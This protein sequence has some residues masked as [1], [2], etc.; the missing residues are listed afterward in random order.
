MTNTTIY[1]GLLSG[2]VNLPISKSIAHR[3]IL[4]KALSGNPIKD[5]KDRNMPDDIW[6]TLQG[7][8]ALVDSLSLDSL[9]I[10]K[11][12]NLS[13]F[14][15]K[16][17]CKDSGTTLRMIMPIACAIH[18]KVQITVTKALAKRP[19]GELI[20][21]LSDHGCKIELI[22]NKDGTFTYHTQGKFQGGQCHIAGN[23]SS[24]YISGLLYALPLT[25]NGGEIQLTTELAS[26]P[27]LDMTLTILRDF[28]INIDVSQTNGLDKFTLSGMQKFK[29]T[30]VNI[31]Q[32]DWSAAAFFAVANALG[33][34]V[35]MNNLNP[36]SIQGDKEVYNFI[37]KIST[38]KCPIIDLE[39][40][41]D[42]FPVLA[43]L[44]CY[45]KKKTTFTG[46]SRLEL[47]ESNRIESTKAMIDALGG[48]MTIYANPAIKVEIQ[49]LGYL[50]GGTVNSYND[51][52]IAMAAAIAASRA[53]GPVT[54]INSSCCDKSYPDFFRDY[55]KLGGK[56]D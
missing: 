47:K 33:S 44:A 52:R 41:P 48:S 31:N 27:Y 11:S 18:D 22:D 53:D 17:Y 30:D 34:Q 38:C 26:K 29:N 10:K 40:H 54:I 28:G 49:G 56:F 4:G 32:G 6:R 36:N 23:I 20:Q 55:E 50:H 15:C 5:Y 39:N 51:H 24:Q 42:L 13:K 25:E 3:V 7:S 46:V 21:V 9:K 2:K 45:N 8:I 37:D 19:L 16:I 35:S 1:P 14:P 12:A 43:V